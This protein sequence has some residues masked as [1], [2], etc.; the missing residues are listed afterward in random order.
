MASFNL[1]HHYIGPNTF[2]YTGILKIVKLV[3]DSYKYTK[4]CKNKL[5]THFERLGEIASVGKIVLKLDPKN[6]LFGLGQAQ[7]WSP[8]LSLSLFSRPQI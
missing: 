5:L 4:E 7:M 2:P 8:N 6:G 3:E 1:Q